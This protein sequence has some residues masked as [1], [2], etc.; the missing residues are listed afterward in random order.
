MC[1]DG[2]DGSEQLHWFPARAARIPQRHDLGRTSCRPRRFTSVVFSALAVGQ[3]PHR[4][5]GTQNSKTGR[6]SHAQHE[7]DHPKNGR[8]SDEE[9][10]PTRVEATVGVVIADLIDD[11]Q[12][13]EAEQHHRQ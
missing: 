2:V 11:D 13:G 7:E 5:Q 1:V 3:V 12:D 8:T 10:T 9:A 6:N 4:L